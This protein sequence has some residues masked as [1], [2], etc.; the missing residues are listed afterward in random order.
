MSTMRRAQ[1]EYGPGVKPSPNGKG[2]TGIYLTV[3]DRITTSLFTFTPELRARLVRALGIE[4]DRILMRAKTALAGHG[5]G[6]LAGSVRR[7]VKAIGDIAV[8]ATVTAGGRKGAEHAHLFEKG[9]SGTETVRQH[10]RRSRNMAA[11]WHAPM[12]ATMHGVKEYRRA[13][14]Y[15]PHRYMEQALDAQQSSVLSAVNVAIGE[16]AQAVGVGP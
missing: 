7:N 16:T 5:T 6:R 10:L 9:F 13:V 2:H 1:V 12:R 15:K 8:R 14:T 11:G 3:E 4:A